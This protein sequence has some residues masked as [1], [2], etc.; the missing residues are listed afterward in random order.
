M[1]FEAFVIV[2]MLFL[3]LFYLFMSCWETFRSAWFIDRFK[4]MDVDTDDD[5]KDIT[6]L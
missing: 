1:D 4:K 5:I 2:C 3:I 6:K